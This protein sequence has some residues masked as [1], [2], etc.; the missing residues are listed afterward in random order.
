MQTDVKM[1]V[2]V[3]SFYSVVVKRF[4]DIVLSFLALLVLS[5]VLLIVCV[6]ELVYHGAPVFYATKRPGKDGKIIK[7]Y[8]FRSM[9]NERDENGLLLP[10]DKRITK[11]GKIIR[12]LSVDELPE[13]WS[14]LKGDMSII[15][16]RPLL[17]EYLDYYN[18]RHAMRHSVRPGLACVRIQNTESKTWTWRE[19]FENDIYYIE[20]ISLLT[21]I[22]MIFAVIK[23]VFKGAEYRADDTRTPFVGD[24]LDDTRSKSEL[25]EVVHFSSI[26]GR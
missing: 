1:P 24:N 25:E 2:P 8:K 9:T 17:I 21:D 4:F 22:K 12:K 5:P 13:L 23:E 10:E 20:H 11:F 15:G 19:Q 14:I 7:I 26:E 18:P 16:P 3:K 6:L